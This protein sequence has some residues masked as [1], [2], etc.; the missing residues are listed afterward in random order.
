MLKLFSTLTEDD[1]LVSDLYR[2]SITAVPRGLDTE[3][4]VW[5]CAHQ[6][7]DW[8]VLNWRERRWRV[9]ETGGDENAP[10]ARHAQTGTYFT[11][12]GEPYIAV[13][14]GSASPANDANHSFANVFIYDIKQRLWLPVPTESDSQADVEKLTPRLFHTSTFVEIEHDPH[15]VVVGGI[16]SERVVTS[17]LPTPTTVNRRASVLPELRFYNL[18]LRKWSQPIYV[19]GRYRH[20][21][22]LIPSATEPKV[23]IIGGR[24]IKG[25]LSKEPF[26]IDVRSAFQSLKYPAGRPSSA[27]QGNGAYWSW[28]SGI[29]QSLGPYYGHCHAV[30]HADSVV[31]FAHPDR[32]M[33]ETSTQPEN[34]RSR[35]SSSFRSPQRVQPEGRPRP[36]GQSPSHRSDMHTGYS[37][38][39]LSF[40]RGAASLRELRRLRRIS[41]KAETAAQ[42]LATLAGQQNHNP[43]SSTTAPTLQSQ[44][45]STSH[46]TQSAAKSEWLW[47]GVVHSGWGTTTGGQE[48]LLLLMYQIEGRIFLVPALL[49][50]LGVPRE[51][52]NGVDLTTNFGSLPGL[53]DLLPQLWDGAPQTSPNN[54]LDPTLPP[55]ADF[56]LKT[57][58]PASP[59]IILH[60]SILF[61]RSA[62]FRALLTSGFNESRTGEATVEE[63]YA[64]AYALCHWIYTSSLPAWLE[65]PSSLGR[66][67]SLHMSLSIEARYASHAGE[68]LCDLLI[69]ANARMLPKLAAR[70]RQLIREQHMRIPELAP[71]VW[72]AADLTDMNDM[73]DL[74]PFS[75][76]WNDGNTNTSLIEY[77]WVG[78]VVSNQRRPPES[79][80]QFSTAVS[81]WCC[82]GGPEVQAAM[83][84]AKEWLDPETWRSW[85]EK[86]AKS[87][88]EEAPPLQSSE[89]HVQGVEGSAGVESDIDYS[90]MLA[91]QIGNNG[92]RPPRVL[93]VPEL[94]SLI[95]SFSRI[96]DCV[97]LAQ[98]CRP[99][100]KVATAFV[101]QHV[102]GAQNLLTLLSGTRIITQTKAP[103]TNEPN[104]KKIVI[105][106]ASSTV[107][108]TRF[109]I[110]APYVRRLNIYGSSAQYYQVSGWSP[111]VLRANSKTLLPNLLSIVIQSAHD[112]HGP[113]QVMW[114]RAFASPSLL[115]IQA[116]PGRPNSRTP[117]RVSPSAASVILDIIAG[118]CPRL[119]RLSLFVSEA[120]PL[121]KHDGENNMLC[122][123]WKRP[124]YEYLRAFPALFELTCCV[125]ML[126]PD[127]LRLIA[128]LPHLSRLSV[129]SSGNRIVLRPPALSHEAFPSLR[130]LCLQGVDPYEAA[131]IMRIPSIMKHLTT[132]ELILHPE[133]LDEDEDREEWITSSLLTLLSNCPNLNM[134]HLD[135][136]PNLDLEDAYDIG[137]Q[138]V[139]DTFSK[140]PLVSLTLSGVHIS[141][142]ASTGSLRTVWPSVTTLRM[143]NQFASPLILSCFAQLPRLQHLTLNIYLEGFIACPKLPS[144][145]PLHTLEISAGGTAFEPENLEYTSRFLL[146]LF[147]SLRR[148]VWAG[149]HGDETPE[150]AAQRRFIGFLNHHLTMRRELEE[151]RARCA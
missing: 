3:L 146:S 49:S 32:T 35:R 125:F 98:T 86:R 83:E 143:R 81:H 66:D 96:S 109:D 92:R 6:N 117:P 99:V 68:I 112:D 85:F 150:Q 130:E 22:V 84:N 64:A 41:Q 100:F 110:Y 71:L 123:F 149:Y 40:D 135:L 138:D 91:I 94:L 62:Y 34:E 118:C 76:S 43:I 142:W 88:R 8:I 108:F 1:H 44:A 121:D 103:G 56:A 72:R 50:A 136:D 51:G 65:N 55:F 101:W 23:M 31:I 105:G 82:E 60:R 77:P 89:P 148:V 30:S 111:L 124:Y 61:A 126:E 137:D 59:P 33:R 39:A 14:G 120:L 106:M 127:P 13:L 139:M 48:D 90:L 79:R 7:S 134:F 36:P 132:L 27:D 2:G 19:P 141:D 87:K 5:G 74:V 11:M 47:C 18:R 24:D 25:N 57:S 9:V 20:S 73:E 107:D 4:Y 115:T 113:D 128:S 67:D 46:L 69:A 12:V 63:G 38:W 10:S 70:V 145:C 45:H 26:I 16:F 54:P 97:R 37:A 53:Y 104:C 52:S 144:F 119:M 78:Q 102:D 140:L 17:N 28:F 21:A 133:R 122:F 42:N 114:I 58:T 75:H 93:E 147:P 80:R 151:L 95:C 116:I 129:Y 29:V 131:S 15:L